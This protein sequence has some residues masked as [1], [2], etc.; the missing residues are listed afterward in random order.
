MS[1]PLPIIARMKTKIHDQ[2]PGRSAVPRRVSALTR[3]RVVAKV[4]AHRSLRPPFEHP[5]CLQPF[6]FAFRFV[7]ICSGLFRLKIFS[8]RIGAPPNADFQ[9]LEPPFTFR[10]RYPRLSTI[11]NF[12]GE[13]TAQKMLLPAWIAGRVH[14]LY[15][16]VHA[17][18]R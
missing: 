5:S 12:P 16:L 2:C 17:G 1:Y 18:T 3:R 7:Q 4:N 6:S 15:T 14:A 11:K 10:P 8:G 9:P 13:T